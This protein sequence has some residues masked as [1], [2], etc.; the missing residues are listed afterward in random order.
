MF[1]E[2]KRYSFSIIYAILNL[3]GTL[4]AIAEFCCSFDPN[5]TKTTTT[6]KSKKLKSKNK[7]NNKKLI[8][9]KK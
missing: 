5:R 9:N 4:P 3:R 2:I 6:K 8:I 7:K 1:Q